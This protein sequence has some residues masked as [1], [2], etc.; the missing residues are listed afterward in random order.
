MGK[1]LAAI[2]TIGAIF[3]SGQDCLSQVPSA[4]VPPA[5]PLTSQLPPPPPPL[6]MTPLNQLPGQANPNANQARQPAPPTSGSRSAVGQRGFAPNMIGDFFGGATN[7]SSTLMGPAAVFTSGPFDVITVTPITQL[8]SYSV[9]VGVYNSSNNSPGIVANYGSSVP[10]PAET[11]VIPGPKFVDHFQMQGSN[12]AFNQLAASHGFTG[13]LVPGSYQA[14]GGVPV[15]YGQTTFPILA[16]PGADIPVSMRWNQYN[17]QAAYS[18]EYVVNVPSPAAGGVIGRM[19][20]A[21]NT[22]PLPRDRVF[23]NYSYFN[24]V[25]LIANGVDV[26]RFTPGFE[27]TLFNGN[28]SI[29]VR[30]PFASTLSN[31]IVADG[32]TNANSTQFGNLTLYYKQLLYRSETNAVSGGLGIA[33]P[34]ASD[35]HVVTSAG[36]SLVNIKNESIHLLPFLGHLYTP[37]EQFFFQQFLQFDFDTNGDPVDVAGVNGVMTSAGR[38]ND[39]TFLY[40]SVS[41]GYW[42]YDNPD[43]DHLFNRIAPIVELHYNRS[44]QTT[45]V[46]SANGFQIGN[47]SDNVEVLNATVGMTAMMGQSK[48]LTVGYVTPLGGGSDKQFNGELRLI[49]NW[50]FGA[51]AN[52]ATR[53]QF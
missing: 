36:A 26:N 44:L 23:F 42:L 38:A 14:V 30:A 28:A 27:K 6:R 9:G 2:V 50:F 51:P 18:P 32:V 45:D 24:G 19:K 37:N 53:V 43:S 13:Q 22:S 40:Y 39:V 25:P 46:V 52:R 21:E 5:P 1:H 48:T 49:F 33:L 4:S 29:E 34:T 3:L 15:V 8:P 17:L 16:A 7:S 35:M 10:L 31:N 20:I 11:G 12:A 41:A 47:Y